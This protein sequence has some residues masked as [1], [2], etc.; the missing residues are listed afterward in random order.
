MKCQIDLINR[1]DQ[2]LIHDAPICTT[3]R[4]RGNP[5]RRP[6]PCCGSVLDLPSPIADDEDRTTR[7]A[8]SPR[9]HTQPRAVPPPPRTPPVLT[10][11]TSHSSRR[12]SGHDEPPRLPRVDSST[13]QL[14]PPASLRELPLTDTD[15]NLRWALAWSCRGRTTGPRSAGSVNSAIVRRDGSTGLHSRDV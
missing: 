15:T 6:P 2:A 1:C 11:D 4:H 13:A 9:S 12:S 14:R 8:P 7:S 3:A 5:R 10:L